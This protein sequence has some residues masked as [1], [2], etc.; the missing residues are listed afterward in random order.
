M[1]R[2][3]FIQ[4][5]YSSLMGVP[6]ALSLRSHHRTA[7]YPIMKKP[8][9]ETPLCD[10]LGIQYPVIQAGMGDV[11]GPELVA[12][13]SNAG[14]LGILTGTMLPPDILRERI[15]KIRELTD[16]PFGVNLLLH[17]DLYPPAE[18]DLDT[19]VVQQVQGVLNGFRHE[20]GIPASN[21]EPSGVP[22]LI[23]SDF[24]VIVEES[25]PVFS[26][27]LGNPSGEMVAACHQKG[28]KVMVMVS[29]VEDA[30]AVAANRPDVIVA[31]GS[32]AGGHRSTWEKKPTNEFAAIGTLP[33][34]AAIVEA[35]KIPV[36]AAGGIVNGKG[37]MAAL[38]LGAQGAL[39]GTRFVVTHESMAPDF[40]KQKIL[41]AS[42]DQTTVTDIFTGMFAR[43]IRNRFTRLYAG[44]NI[45]VL[46]PGR[47]YGV[48]MD[49]QEAAGLQRNP[50]FF[51]LYAGQGLDLIQEI[52]SAGDI[53]KEIIAEAVNYGMTK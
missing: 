12:A 19:A 40:Y 10:L 32:E 13:V 38:M 39:I 9:L 16:K 25:V 42:S 14:G 23:Q 24:D 46:P 41:A 11:A 20:L 33:L 6:A 18:H 31:Q 5:G 30:L 22:P 52:K 26:V 21:L 17:R 3:K 28:M 34:T 15:G 36:V 27:G 49:I 45:P 50:D 44:K 47:Q 37:L 7:K 51:A 8:K 35:V 48:S 29:T 43:V 2:R 1:K 53:V 4:L